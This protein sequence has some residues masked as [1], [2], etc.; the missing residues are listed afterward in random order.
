LSATPYSSYLFG[1]TVSMGERI[2]MEVNA[3]RMKGK[4]EEIIT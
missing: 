1:R 4:L 3:A 2:A